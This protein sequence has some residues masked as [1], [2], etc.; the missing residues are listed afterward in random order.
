M[1]E[2]FKLLAKAYEE[3]NEEAAV[4]LKAEIDV[5]RNKIYTK[6][7]QKQQVSKCGN[8]LKARFNL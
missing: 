4:E 3:E 2:L 7:L 6:E 8:I 5:L 1:D